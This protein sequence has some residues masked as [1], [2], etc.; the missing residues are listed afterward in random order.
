MDRVIF[1]NLG[2][3]LAG[4]KFELGTEREMISR[5]LTFELI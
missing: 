3:T 5:T 1:A 4:A 2:E